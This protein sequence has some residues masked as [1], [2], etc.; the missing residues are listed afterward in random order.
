MSNLRSS[1]KIVKSPSVSAAPS[2]AGVVAT[3][4]PSTGAEA[5]RAG[6]DEPVSAVA[7]LAALDVGPPEPCVPLADAARCGGR[8]APGPVGRWDGAGR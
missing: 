5:G 4:V 2:S 3:A 6:G 8:T 1:A 7:G